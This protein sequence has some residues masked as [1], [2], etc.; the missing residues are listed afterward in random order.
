MAR[1][2]EI[3]TQRLEVERRRREQALA[4]LQAQSEAA[5]ARADVVPT[6]ATPGAD[7]QASLTSAQS[8]GEL[9]LFGGH[10][11]KVFLGCFCDESEGNSILNKYGRFGNRYSTDSSIWNRYGDFG[12][13][14]A[15]TSVCNPYALDPPIVVTETGKALGYLTENRYMLGAITDEAVQTWLS[16]VVCED[17]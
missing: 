10:D 7:T 13:R 1:L 17:S 15:N 14:Y 2:Q 6:D 16:K 11:H 8:G 5:R 12:S 4:L 3:E 9:L